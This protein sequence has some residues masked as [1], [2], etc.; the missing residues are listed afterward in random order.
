MELLNFG[1]DAGK[2]ERWTK[3]KA[4]SKEHRTLFA[5]FQKWTFVSAGFAKLARRASTDYRTHLLLLQRRWR[6]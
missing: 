1:K 4:L 3:V 2:E 5:I 6:N